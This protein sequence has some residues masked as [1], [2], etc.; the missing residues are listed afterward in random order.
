MS[1]ELRA[2]MAQAKYLRDRNIPQAGSSELYQ[3]LL[4][5]EL[6]WS[7]YSPRL[8]PAYSQELPQADVCYSNSKFFTN[9]NQ[10]EQASVNSYFMNA[11]KEPEGDVFKQH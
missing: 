4:C 11:T 7:R 3:A 9:T 2:A 5:Q 8:V 6:S 10:Y 1:Y